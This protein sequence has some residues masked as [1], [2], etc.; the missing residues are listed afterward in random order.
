MEDTYCFFSLFL[1]VHHLCVYFLFECD[2]VVHTSWRDD[3]QLWSVGPCRGSSLLKG[4]R[5]HTKRTS[6][7]ISYKRT[8]TIWWFLSQ[9][10]ISPFMVPRI[11]NF[12]MLLRETILKHT[13]RLGEAHPLWALQPVILGHCE[14]SHCVVLNA[15]ARASKNYAKN[16][17][18]LSIMFKTKE[19]ISRI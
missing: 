12:S 15:T 16:N 2:I 5:G 9:C 10:N 13:F 17:F 3:L 6:K 19:R 11:S 7:N 18:L 4:G 1:F 8:W 14:V